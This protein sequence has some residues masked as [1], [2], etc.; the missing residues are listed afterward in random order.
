MLYLVATPIGNLDDVSL[1]AIEVLRTVDVVAS[2]DTRHTAK[3]LARHQIKARQMPFHEHNEQRVAGRIVK[4]LRDGHDVALVS[5]AGT[6]G[7]ADPGFSI[8]RRCHDEGLPVTM[9]PGPAAL[10][11]AVVLSGLPLHAFTFRGFPPRKSGK[12]RRFLA[13][14]A[15]SPHTLV[16]YESPYRIKAL[17]EDALEVYGDRRAALCNDLT[18]K[19]EAVHRGTLREL[20]QRLEHEGAK[21][22]YVLVVEGR[23][24]GD[25]EGDDEGEAGPGPRS[26][27]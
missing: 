24:E 12:R 13:I 2:E 17:V 14:D 1:R 6:P 20:Y 10:V 3:L 18:K 25:D 21:G 9:V 22:E 27:L 5:D 4:L 16:F 26:M 11:M 23:S 8:V 19:F 7:I 15:Q